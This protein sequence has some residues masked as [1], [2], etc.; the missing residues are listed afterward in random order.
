MR[1]L[2]VTKKY[3]NALGGDSIGSMNLEKQQKKLGHE[4]F[5]LTTNCDE[6]IDKPNVIRKSK[7]F[8][9][10]SNWI[11]GSGKTT[12]EIRV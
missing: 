12:V 3:P 7:F 5:I 1:I 9:G 6:I 8:G 4:V 2:H 11:Y 10:R